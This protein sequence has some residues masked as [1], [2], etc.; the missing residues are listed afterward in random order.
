MTIILTGIEPDLVRAWKKWCGD[1]EDVEIFEGSIF[2]AR[3]EAVVSPANSFGFMDGGL[4]LLLSRFFGWHVQQE[5][6]RLIREHHHGELLVGAAEIV[7]TRHERIPFLISA[8]TMR[9]PMI[10]RDSI[11]PYL[12]ARAVLLLIQNGTF[13][14]GEYAGWPI[15][16]HVRRVAFPGLGTGVGQVGPDVCA[17]QVRT[18][19]EDVVLQTRGFPSTWAQA[20]ARHQ[21]LYTDRIRDLQREP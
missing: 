15:R 12:A 4:D 6:Q 21:Q 20:Q 13:K 8:P 18:A 17:H 5:L 14:S 10:L 2:E 9:V 11:N 19:T 7:S 1:V 16:D 3:C